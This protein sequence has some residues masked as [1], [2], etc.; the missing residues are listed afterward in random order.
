MKKRLDPREMEWIC[1]PKLYITGS[2]RIVIETEPYTDILPAGN[3]AEAIE[4]NIAPKGSFC[5]EVRV[6]F[7]FHGLLDQCGISL[8]QGKERKAQCGTVCHNREAMRLQTVIYHDD[9]GDLAGLSISSGIRWMYYRVWYRSGTVRF[10]YSY[11]G[12]RY[13]EFRNFRVEEGG[14]PLR[15]GIYACSPGNSW[16]DCTFSKMTLEEEDL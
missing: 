5:F 14:E 6:D 11:N 15:I 9:G 1:E 16:F 12:D 7:E 4:L 2:D 10:Q 3:S 13:T 8:Y